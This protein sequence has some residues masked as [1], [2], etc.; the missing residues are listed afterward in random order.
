MFEHKI[1]D[2][3]SLLESVYPLHPCRCKYRFGCRHFGS[4]KQIQGFTSN[5]IGVHKKLCAYAMRWSKG[6]QLANL[7][8]VAGLV[9]GRRF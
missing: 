9:S 1:E 2:M 7:T 3:G 4:Q 6:R 5:G 8:A